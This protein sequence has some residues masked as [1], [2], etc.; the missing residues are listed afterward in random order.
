MLV[1][2][3]LFVDWCSALKCLLRKVLLWLLLLLLVLGEPVVLLLLL[4]WLLLLPP[5]LL[6]LLLPLLVLPEVACTAGWPGFPFRAL[7][8][9]LLV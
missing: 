7:L 8:L 1:L 9:L 5:L 3:L 6:L 4:P 2:L